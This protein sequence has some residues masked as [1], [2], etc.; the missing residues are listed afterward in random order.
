MKSP[1]A[2]NLPKCHLYAN[3]VLYILFLLGDKTEVWVAAKLLSLRVMLYI[4]KDIIAVAWDVLVYS[5]DAQVQN[6]GSGV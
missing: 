6:K 2:L 4:S 5:A 1:R 3:N